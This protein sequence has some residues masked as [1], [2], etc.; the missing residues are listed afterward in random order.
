MSTYI[1][2]I[3]N[4]ETS[5]FAKIWLLSLSM[6]DTYFL[7][8]KIENILNEYNIDWQDMVNSNKNI[9]MINDFLSSEKMNCLKSKVSDII[10]GLSCGEG[11]WLTGLE[12][13]ISGIPIITT[14]FSAMTDYLIDYG[15]LVDYE[16]VNVS[17]SIGKRWYNPKAKWANPDIEDAIEKLNILIDR[18][19]GNDEELEKYIGEQ[20]QYSKKYWSAENCD[21][22]FR[23][24]LNDSLNKE[25]NNDTYLYQRDSEQ[26][27]SFDDRI[28]ELSGYSRIQIS[29]LEDE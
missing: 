3:D 5:L 16:L 28:D 14:N 7:I 24:A 26:F 22:L 25:I 2:S 10:L 6:Q 27:L 23:I 20:K 18:V 9:V 19:N 17:Q 29:E 11:M 13:T 1:Q 12:A 21:R 4:V 8:E 15:N